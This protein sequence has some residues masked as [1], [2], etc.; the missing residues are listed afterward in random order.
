MTQ[1]SLAALQTKLAVDAAF[2]AELEGA[3]TIADAI[4]IAAAHDIA[5]TAEDLS[6]RERDLSDAELDG[7]SGGFMS[8]QLWGS[9]TNNPEMT[10]CPNR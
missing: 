1:E 10:N 6:N 8:M 2:K 3:A 9:C 4:A 7:A 5:V